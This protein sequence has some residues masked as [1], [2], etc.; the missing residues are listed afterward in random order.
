MLTE[1]TSCWRKF[2]K[3]L[4]ARIQGDDL[5]HGRRGTRLVLLLLLHQECLMLLSEPL[6]LLV[7]ATPALFISS[8]EARTDKNPEE[9]QGRTRIDPWIDGLGRDQGG[10]PR[11]NQIGA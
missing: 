4:E 1:Q 11:C 10:K 8:G 2:H 7:V 3:N 5:G 6:L 9:D